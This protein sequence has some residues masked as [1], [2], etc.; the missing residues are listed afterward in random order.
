MGA[1]GAKIA[2]QNPQEEEGAARDAQRCRLCFQSATS[3]AVPP[4]GRGEAAFPTRIRIRRATAVAASNAWMP[5]QQTSAA[6]ATATDARVQL[7]C[8]KPEGATT[9]QTRAA[10]GGLRNGETAADGEE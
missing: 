2:P 3:R 5:V 7:N 10:E 4:R 6:T 9:L 1:T 8:W